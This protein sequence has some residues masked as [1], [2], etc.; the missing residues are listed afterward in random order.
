MLAQKSNQHSGK[1][2]K[3]DDVD[4]L[5]E[6]VGG[7][8]KSDDQSGP[9]ESSELKSCGRLCTCQFI[10]SKREMLDYGEFEQNHITSLR[11]TVKRLES[12]IAREYCLKD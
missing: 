4:D 12:A 6:S 11:L 5:T 8:A 10:R 2:E 3:R 9:N 7:W 1:T